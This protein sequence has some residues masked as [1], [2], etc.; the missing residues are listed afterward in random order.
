MAKQVPD[1]I[2]RMTD[3]FIERIV[4]ELIDNSIQAKSK[5]VLVDFVDVNKKKGDIGIAVFDDGNGFESPEALFEAMEIEVKDK[6]R[7]DDEIGKYHVGMKLAPLSKYNNLFLISIIDGKVW[8]TRA[9]NAANTGKSFDMENSRHFNPTKPKQYSPS[10]DTIPE[11]VHELLKN[12]KFSKPKKCDWT[13]CV[14]ASER[15]RKLLEDGFDAGKLM[16]DDKQYPRLLTRFLGITYQE[17]LEEMDLEITVGLNNTV[18]PLDPFWDAYTPASIDSNVEALEASLVELKNKGKKDG[19]L[20]TGEKKEITAIGNMIR[21]AKALRKFCTFRGKKYASTE[22]EGL[23]IT[24]YVL[25]VPPSRTLI[26]EELHPEGWGVGTSPYLGAQGGGSGSNLLK[27]DNLGGFFFYRDKR[28][29]TF[30]KFH[31]LNVTN[32]DANS[33][34]IKVKFP[35]SLDDQIQV[36]TNKDKIDSFSD[37]AWE[38]IITGLELKSGSADYASPFNQNV[39]FFDSKNKS[40]PPKKKRTGG[41]FRPEGTHYQNVLVRNRKEWLK[42]IECNECGLLH[43]IGD[44][45]PEAEC[46]V[47]NQKGKGC[48]PSDCK[49]ECSH[50]GRIGEHGDDKCPKL[51]QKCMIVHEDGKCP[52]SC[53]VC[54]SPDD[55]C[56]CPC[57]KCGSPNNPC[58]CCEKCGSPNNPCDCPQGNNKIDING[59]K[60]L[61]KMYQNN[62]EEN[63]QNIKQAMNQLGITIEDL[64]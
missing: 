47:C 3:L 17:Y 20:S 48:E 4:A 35:S 45:C 23:E 52:K 64:K 22:V 15:W 49:H 29:I 38:E 36:S 51:C 1:I 6:D 59:P 44:V 7:E 32:N 57:E 27:S 24:P 54:G 11:Y 37:L 30:G 58:D 2:F 33:I 10:D 18:K 28:L 63:I 19:K 21:V 50:C 25:P 40:A 46:P 9:F 41:V 55:P 39:P 34:R 26:K 5:K 31:D 16:L 61:L 13:T 43:E 8:I 56:D 53:D 60:V 42:Y 14:I 62:K 12:S